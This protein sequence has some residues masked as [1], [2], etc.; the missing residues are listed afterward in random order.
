MWR[1]NLTKNISRK[2]ASATVVLPGEFER[3]KEIQTG[4]ARYTF[5]VRL[6]HSLLL[7]D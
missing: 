4:V 5:T 2:L 7:A 3:A 1:K 6:F